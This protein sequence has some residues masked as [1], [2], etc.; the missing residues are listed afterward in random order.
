MRKYY[1]TSQIVIIL[2]ITFFLASCFSVKP[3]STKSGKKL[4]ETFYLGEGGSLYF[5]KPIKFFGENSEMLLDFTFNSN[6]HDTSMSIVNGSFINKSLVGKVDSIT[7]HS[8]VDVAIKEV[9]EI[10]NERNSANQFISRFTFKLKT[11]DL[12]Q[13]FQDGFS[14]EI[15]IKN[16]VFKSFPSKKSKRKI[17]KLNEY[18]FI[19][20]KK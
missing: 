5:I 13:L 15:F 20:Y 4:Y 9:K 16:E 19:F 3:S 18:L 8:K 2:I 10:F 1:N 6:V 12:I 17:N 11:K 7:F 14:H